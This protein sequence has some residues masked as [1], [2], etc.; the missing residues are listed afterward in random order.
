MCGIAGAFGLPH[1]DLAPMLA[2]MNHRGPDDA[3][4]FRDDRIAMGMTRLA[5]LD[6]SAAG[7]QPMANVQGSIWIVYNGEAY[8]F[9]EQRQLLEKA[10]VSFR[11]RSDTEVL[12]KLYEKYGDDFLLRVRGMFALAI[13]D[14]RGGAGRERLLLARDPL[15]IKPLLYAQRGDGLIFASELKALIASGEVQAQTD[16][17]ALRGLLTF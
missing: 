10:G 8:N 13:Y 9:L 12:L 5:V 14:R 17:D 6:T 4:S 16:P 1:F 3:G 7:H 11:S 2:A 15:G